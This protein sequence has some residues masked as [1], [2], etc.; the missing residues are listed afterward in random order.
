MSEFF[1][2]FAVL[3][4]LAG[5]SSLALSLFINLPSPASDWDEESPKGSS[6]SS[7]QTDVQ[8][9]PAAQSG[10]KV[11]LQG[12]VEKSGEAALRIKRAAQDLK[13]MQPQADNPGTLEGK[14]VDDELRGLLKDNSLQKM[15]PRP[16]DLD[17][18]LQGQASLLG[19]KAGSK[20]DPDED[21]AELLVEWDR[22]R[23]RFLRAVQLGTQEILNNPDPDDYVRPRVDPYTGAISS[24]FPLGTGCAFS[25]QITA[26]GQIRN[27][28]LIETSAF[29]K[30]DKAVLRAVQQLEGTQILRFPKGSHRKTVVQPGRIKTA[31]SN[32]FKYHRFGDVER[33]PG[34]N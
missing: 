8:S 15:I 24:R 19:G 17:K 22:W 5:A 3:I 9:P 18:P 6:N 7:S 12:K 28:E 16:G 21:D 27:L 29:P 30:Y 26:E 34:S 1:V 10:G 20:L 11:P 2:N 4:R 32:E 23:N 25:C 13:D 14:A 31:N 33:V